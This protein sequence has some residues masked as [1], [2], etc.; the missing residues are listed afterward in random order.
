M[1][2]SPKL[3]PFKSTKKKQKLAKPKLSNR[4]LLRKIYSSRTNVSITPNQMRSKKT[5]DFDFDLN[6]MM[7][8]IQ[9]EQQEE[10]IKC[11]SSIYES[12]VE[13]Y[14]Q[15]SKKLSMQSDVDPSINFQKEQLYNLLIPQINSQKVLNMTPDDQES[16]KTLYE[17]QTSITFD[18]LP[19]IKV[20]NQLQIPKI[21][22]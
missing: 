20:Q 3:D 7:Q 2:L 11:Q 16:T 21:T 4:A 14:S 22:S 19:K 15:S 5:L 8:T 9:N 1:S 6:K 10:D 18:Y 17:N 13:L 12:R